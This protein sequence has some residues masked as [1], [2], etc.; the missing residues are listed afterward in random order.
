MVA[1]A[2]TFAQGYTYQ[3]LVRDGQN[4]G[5]VV[6]SGPATPATNDSGQVAFIAN[7]GT[8]PGVFTLAGPVALQGQ[9]V[10]GKVLTGFIDSP[11]ISPS[12]HVS[13]IAT[14][15]GG[16]GIFVDQTLLVQTG[17][18]IGGQTVATLHGPVLLDDSGGVLFSATPTSGQDGVFTATAFL[19]FG[20][21]PRS[22]T[23][24]AIVYTSF[25]EGP[26]A[27]QTIGLQGLTYK[28]G[29]I[30]DGHTISQLFVR[31]G[32]PAIDG[33]GR[34]GFAGI[35]FDGTAY[36]TGV[37]VGDH[38]VAAGGHTVGS[39]TLDGSVPPPVAGYEP[40]DFTMN[41]SGTVAFGWSADTSIY[42]QYGVVARSVLAA[43]GI[44]STVTV[45]G[46]Y[47]VGQAVS[48]SIDT[49]GRI[50]FAAVLGHNASDAFNALVR[51]TP[52]GSPLQ[53]TTATLP[54]GTSGQSYSTTL[55]ASGGSGTGYS[56]SLTAGTLPTGF[57]LSPAGLLSSTGSQI[58]APQSY[59][60]TVS[61]ADSAGNTATQQFTLTI[62]PG[63]TLPSAV[64]G[65][66]YDSGQLTLAGTAGPGIGW[67]LKSGNLPSEFS[68]LLTG[69]I[70]DPNAV[71]S[72]PG[73]YQFQLSTTDSNNNQVIQGFTLVILGAV[74]ILDPV[75]QL[76]N[77][78]QITGARTLLASQGRPVQGIAADGIAQVVFRIPT[79]AAGD[80]VTATILLNEQCSTPGI[81]ST[82][83]VSTPSTSSDD[84][85]GLFSV[86]SSVT[87]SQ[88]LQ[89][90]ATDTADTTTLDAFVAY[91]APIDFA[92]PSSST[93][94]ALSSRPVYLQLIYSA[95]GADGTNSTPYAS[96]IVPLIIVRPPVFLVHGF[97]TDNSAWDT[98]TPLIADQSFKIYTVNYG[99]HL[100]QP[101]FTFLIDGTSVTTYTPTT[102]YD[103]MTTSPAYSTDTIHESAR[104]S[105][106]GFTVSMPVVVDAVLGDIITFK[107]GDN[108]LGSPVASV[109]ADF[110]AHSMGG[111]VIRYWAVDPI[112]YLSKTTYG[113]GGI[114]KLITLGTP[115][116]GTPQ[117]VLA[118]NSASSCSRTLAALAD[119]LFLTSANLTGQSKPIPGAAG[120]LSGDGLGY[121]MSEP[122][123]KLA[124][125][126]S[127]F[128]IATLAGDIRS[129]VSDLGYVSRFAI[130]PG[131]SL[132]G[133]PLGS[134]YDVAD[135]ETI[136]D[137]RLATF[138]LTPISQSVSTNSDGSVP[139][140]SALMNRGKTSC[141]IDECFSG[142]AH[143]S[144]I[145]TF[146]HG[147]VNY[148]QDSS[149]IVSSR[150]VQL[151][152]TNIHVSPF[153]TGN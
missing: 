149:Q 101:E 73:Q 87:T 19:G 22:N 64:V 43:G 140:R 12:G 95:R 52:A 98:F 59:G 20:L 80:Q 53:V 76:L 139:L 72:P 125:S 63:P 8:T 118:T 146:F 133:D 114:H 9:T 150:V 16:S 71:Q 58:A 136:F 50:V 88:S 147:S 13:Y 99:Q 77:G 61:V 112:L 1:V 103:I 137:P 26:P 47:P 57:V 6:V 28:E 145:A 4:V 21:S 89:S 10:S 83:L 48:P 131:C 135:F 144:G 35:Y 142:Y 134:R 86:G 129:I 62:D 70:L 75:P 138:P 116:V 65:Q 41:S 132:L 15:A 38:L 96:Q 7:A 51:A 79:L 121:T 109:A 40:P 30:V 5:G 123:A 55:A 18:V 74:T 127:R 14:F 67:A 117:A 126:G 66:P 84:N 39:V 11:S 153:I 60:F 78:P 106:L 29:A 122:L 17:Q 104:F 56:W 119:S 94:S 110:V 111:L 37:F 152:N 151:L 85:G 102:T 25:T 3:V 124:A 81:P 2:R 100:Y 128:P 82:C 45:V 68:V 27:I 148:L 23:A 91:R 42:T 107:S 141:S 44:D 97:N 115:H 49:A 93:D 33:T 32:P 113:Q 36:R 46:E 105:H 34:V 31:P 120:E 90:N 130:S 69:K 108:P 143:S 92:R 24:G 54:N